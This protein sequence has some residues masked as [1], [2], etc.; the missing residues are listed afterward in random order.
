MAQS[1]LQGLP[2]MVSNPDKILALVRQRTDAAACSFRSGEGEGGVS[3]MGTLR[4]PPFSLFRKPT[5]SRL[6]DDLC[7]LRVFF[8]NDLRYAGSRFAPSLQSARFSA[9]S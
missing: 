5:L 8:G 4:H 7:T 6:A 9:L 2:L 3:Y 1:V